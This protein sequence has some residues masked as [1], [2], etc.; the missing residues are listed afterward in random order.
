MSWETLPPERR[1]NEYIRR[2]Y[3]VV[4]PSRQLVPRPVGVQWAGASAR[5]H[6]PASAPTRRPSHTPVPPLQ[7]WTWREAAV[8]VFQLHNETLNILSHLGGFV[9]FALFAIYM[10]LSHGSEYAHSLYERMHQLS[11]LAAEGLQRA[12]STLPPRQLVPRW[13]VAVF[14]GGAMMCLGSSAFCHTFYCVS[15]RLSVFIWRF[16]YAGIAAMIASSFYPPIFYAFMCSPRT[17][18]AYLGCITACAAASCVTAFA[19]R[20]QH[21]RYRAFRA[22]LFTALGAF[23]VLPMG[24]QLLLYWNTLPAPLLSALAWELLMCC[25]YLSG[26][27]IYA[28]RVPERWWPGVF[29]F[30][31]H[32]HSVFHLLVVAAA[33]VHL[34]A[35]M[36]LLSW[37][38]GWPCSSLQEALY[39]SGTI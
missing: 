36:L 33:C 12:E 18:T 22:S 7:D 4:S 9:L 24:H 19:E 14:L 17:R 6:A 37:R 31:L 34:R 5:L 32:S 28:A 13:P 3:R 38:D 2:G 23:G 15:H 1:D 25:I 21:P 10:S 27:A 8:S 39:R 20:F 30:G 16:D 11:D 29:C 35:C 26:A